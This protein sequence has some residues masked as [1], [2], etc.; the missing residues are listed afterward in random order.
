MGDAQN[1][2]QFMNCVDGR[3]FEF[4]CPEGLAFNE[5]TYRC[6]WPDQVPS[7]DAEAYLG[8]SCPPEPDLKAFGLGFQA[9]YRSYR[10][11]ND[12]QR[13][14]I[15]IEGRPRL[16]NCGEGKAYNELINACDGVENVTGC[17]TP[18]LA[19]RNNID[20]RF[21]NNNNRRSRF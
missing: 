4:N 21:E 8:F 3:G 1:C 10:S 15:C 11:Q 17:A 2:G 12:C 20:L 18:S 7:C 16:Y 6:D 9:G 5:Q 13:Y 19:G 14:Y